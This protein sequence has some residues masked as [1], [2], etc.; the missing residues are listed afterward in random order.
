[1]CLM[2][3]EW[4]LSRVSELALHGMLTQPRIYVEICYILYKYIHY[5]T[6]N[7]SLSYFTYTR[8]VSEL[9]R[10]ESHSC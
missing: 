4:I 8:T 7:R 9:E 5:L 3:M 6:S 1:M 2:K 10:N